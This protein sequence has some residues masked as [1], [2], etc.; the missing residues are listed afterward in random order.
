MRAMLIAMTSSMLIALG[1][2]P[3]SEAR[4]P[5]LTADQEAALQGVT[6]TRLQ[7]SEREL[8]AEAKKGDAAVKLRL[9]LGEPMPWFDRLVGSAMDM[10]EP[11]R[12]GARQCQIRLDDR[13]GEFISDGAST[14]AMTETR[15]IEHFDADMAVAE[16]LMAQL[17]QNQQAWN[18]YRW[19]IRNLGRLAHELQGLKGPTQ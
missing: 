15:P 13:D 9:A 3:A 7:I 8:N 10:W 14:A 2:G 1:C 12:D 5:K 16:G 19:E 11:E 4:L 18:L 17:S 6:I